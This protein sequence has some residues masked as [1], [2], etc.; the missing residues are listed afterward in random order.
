MH[1]IDIIRAIMGASGDGFLSCA[2][3]HTLAGEL[4]VTPLAIA[5]IVNSRSDLRFRRCQLGV[6]GYGPKSEGKHK[7]VLAAQNMPEEIVSAIQGAVLHGAVSC[8]ALWEV[9]EQ[10]GYPRLGIAN[11]VEA[12]SLKI[13]PCQLG[14]F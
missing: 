6:F 3:A 4:D 13:S 9:A 7:I 12:L 8:L 11:I 2:A 10:F 5:D 1:N 14:C